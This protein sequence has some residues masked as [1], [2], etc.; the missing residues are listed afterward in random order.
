M[1][2]V[3]KGRGKYFICP[4]TDFII[5]RI[6]HFTKTSFDNTLPKYIERGARHTPAKRVFTLQTF[7]FVHVN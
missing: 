3:I 4:F 2:R 5:N 7:P 1:K 6:D